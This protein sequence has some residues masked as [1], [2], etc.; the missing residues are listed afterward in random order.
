MAFDPIYT[1][2]LEYVR[3]RVVAKKLGAVV[4]P[5]GDTVAIAFTNPGA[6]PV[7]GD[8]KTAAWETDTSTAPHTYWAVCLVGTG[9]AVTLTEG[10]YSVFV[11]ITD[12][13]EVPVK[14]APGL[15]AVVG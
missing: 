8:W 12:S 4:D 5:T 2:T 11:K 3:V 9:G 14:R 13:P 7:S 10:E 15:L 6:V 1:P